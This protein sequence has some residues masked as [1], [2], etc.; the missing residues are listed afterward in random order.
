MTSKALA[1][2]GIMVAIE[3]FQLTQNF[4]LNRELGLAVSKTPVL[5]P[6]L[7]QQA[8]HAALRLADRKLVHARHIA[9]GPHIH[10]V[11]TGSGQHPFT[12]IAIIY[13][14]IIRVVPF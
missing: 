5:I 1:A 7:Q 4:A 12:R 3:S 13:T 9:I 11:F 14:A 2:L 8:H 6:L 10:C